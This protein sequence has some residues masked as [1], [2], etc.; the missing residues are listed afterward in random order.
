MTL[1]AENRLGEQSSAYLRQHADNPVHWQPWGKQALDEAKRTDRPVLL[2]VGYAAC[3]WCHVMA[4]ECFEDDEVAEIMNRLFVN[5]KVDREERPDIDQI[6]MAALTAMGEQGGW[7]LTM[8]L[9]PE[10]QP[11]WGGTYF[12]KQARYG[13]PGFIDVLHS[14]RRVWEQDKESINH[15]VAALSAH[16]ATRLAGTASASLLDKAVSDR[17][18]DQV[19]SMMDLHNGGLR[20]APKFPNAPF[21]DALWLSWLR[22]GNTAHR[23]AFILSLEIM[24]QG[25]IY[26]H[27]GG[28]LARYSVDERWLAPH[29]EKMLYDN[30]QMIR[31][32]SWAHAQTDNPLFRRRIED[33]VAWLIREMRLPND[34]FASSLD[35]DS[36]GEEG[37]FYVWSADQISA[38]LPDAQSFNAQYD[39][40]PRGNW[41]GKTI[42][43]RLK[44]RASDNL[45]EE[46]AL[47]TDR[48]KLLAERE[49]RIRP[50]RDDKA[51]TDWNGLLIRALAEAAGVLDRPDWAD[52]ARKAYRSISESMREGRLP[53]SVMGESRLYPALSTDYAAMI[54]AALSLYQVDYDKAYIDDAMHFLAQLDRWHIADDGGYNLSASDTDDVI[55]RI[56]G[57]QD[58]AIPSATSQIIEALIRLATATG[59]EYLRERAVAVAEH[60]LG[61]IKNLHYG[62]AGI[63]NAASLAIDPWKLVIVA[64]D[65]DYPLVAEANRIPDPRRTDLLIPIGNDPAAVTLPQGLIPDTKKPAAYLCRG[66]VC[67]PPVETAEEL[68]ALLT[69]RL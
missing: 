41:E 24:L 30:A 28:G 37:K 34:T 1:L 42:L 14:I 63:L 12:P 17:F 19:Y 64:P 43:N 13:R 4:H 47:E 44:S 62:Q 3:H 69:E 54:N 59:E 51:L 55:L 22:N 26:D 67:L 7:P 5:V 31:H 58:E 11:F 9:T 52:I 40:T 60:A 45:D 10:G 15:N 2:S 66:L 56:R 61:R 29:F 57:D 35:A 50:G 53:H 32:A 27:L 65:G 6:Y 36:E 33:T 46:R 23:D 48:Q 68:R 21:M 16:I 38:I 20:G 49:K 39:V 8:F 18:V 25:G